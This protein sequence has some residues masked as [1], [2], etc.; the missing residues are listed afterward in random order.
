M[1]RINGSH[2]IYAM[3]GRR[4]RVVIPVHGSRPLKIGLLRSLMKIV[5]IREGDL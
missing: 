3:E 4:E 1:V 2:H 5:G